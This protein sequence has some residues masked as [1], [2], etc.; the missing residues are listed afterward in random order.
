MI[1]GFDVSSYQPDVNMQ[2]AYNGGARW[3]YIKAT[4][5]TDYISSTFSDQYDD[6]TSA[7]LIRGAYH[8]ANPGVTSGAAQADY[9][10]A[11]GGGWVNISHNS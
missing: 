9:F 4:E 5:N 1:Q 8:F 2:S 3:V 11:H 6:A 7:G 10:V